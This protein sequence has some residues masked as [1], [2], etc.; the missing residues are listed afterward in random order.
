MLA[1]YA[2]LTRVS[3]VYVIAVK[4][5]GN[6]LVGAFGGMLLFGERSQGRL[7]PIFCL[8]AGVAFMSF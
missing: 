1:Y 6:L 7:P 5:G 2:A 4:K 3:K 8:A